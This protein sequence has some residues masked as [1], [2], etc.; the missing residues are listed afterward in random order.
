MKYTFNSNLKSSDIRQA[1]ICSTYLDP[2]KI[3]MLWAEDGFV[4]AFFNEFD[5]CVDA[6]HFKN[7]SKD[8]EAAI[9][10]FVDRM[11]NGG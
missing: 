11:C 10:L 4:V 1:D 9:H 8:I 6:Q 3:M 2:P 5:C 7:S